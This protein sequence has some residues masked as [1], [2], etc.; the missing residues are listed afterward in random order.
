LCSNCH[1]QFS[2]YEKQ[3]VRCGTELFNSTDESKTL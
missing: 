3:C 1:Y 2:W